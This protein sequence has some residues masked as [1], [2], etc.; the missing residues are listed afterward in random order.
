M[1]TYKNLPAPLR[2]GLPVGLV[3]IVG[4]LLMITVF[5][6]EPMTTVLSTQ[7]VN[8]YEQAQKMLDDRGI[9]YEKS[10]KTNTFSLDVRHDQ[11]EAAA[12]TLSR[13]GIIDNR[14]NLPK[15]KVCAPPPGFT[16]TKAA[17]TR[18]DN[19]EDEAQIQQMLMAMGATA[20]GVSVNQEENGNLI[21][22]E[23]SKN[24]SVQVYLPDNLKTT[25]DATSVAYAIKAAIGAPLDHIYIGDG[26]LKPLYN[27]PAEHGAT[28][29]TTAAA[30]TLTGDGTGTS[31]MNS[32]SVGCNDMANATEIATKE[33]A[34][35]ACKRQQIGDVLTEILGSSDVFALSVTASINASA[36]TITTERSTPGP[37][38]S[39]S[40]QKGSGMN[41]Q[42]SSIVPGNETTS[43][44]IP[45]GGISKL[46]ISVA[47]DKRKVGADQV[48]AVKQAL[49]TFV[50]PGRND[51]APTVIR[52][53]LH[54][55]ESAAAAQNVQKAVATTATPATE[56]PVVAPESAR[57]PKSVLILLVLLVVGL[58]ATI[59]VLL[60]RSQQAAAERARYAEEFANQQQVFD[61]FVQQD[62]GAM[63][64]DLES[65]F[66][67]A[68]RGV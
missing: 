44:T 41:T 53:T 54:K 22:P 15:K 18:A 67:P 34:V 49:A 7:N 65:M 39:R 61:T 16:G 57:L 30:T 55:S 28:G 50:N 38:V 51:P 59:L 64:R 56:T 1:D 42:N 45:A 33:A 11:S 32:T 43:A 19:C 23:M 37:T 2:I 66:G 47:L 5:K 48:L 8:T 3:L 46:R 21:G 40:S 14:T 60:R 62:P 35:S 12:A 25:F 52:T 17:N 63:A 10:Q 20:A 26:E 68:P 4:L 9:K 29:S 13:R 31:S 36:K 58:V 27:G 6:K 24:V